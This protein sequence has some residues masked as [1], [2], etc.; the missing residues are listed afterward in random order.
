MGDP[1]GA[2]MGGPVGGMGGPGGETGDPAGAMG[3]PARAMGGPLGGAILL[4][5]RVT[6]PEQ[7]ASLLEEG[8]VLLEKWMILLEQRVSLLEQRVILLKQQVML[9]HQRV[10]LLQVM[11]E[12]TLT[13]KEVPRLTNRRQHMRL[14][15]SSSSKS[16]REALAKADGQND[17]VPADSDSMIELLRR[18]AC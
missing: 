11:Q 6:L 9:Q 1:A 4:D 2:I 14:T 18:F 3:D 7:W 12:H 13:E 10:I 17:R 15:N 8:V 5:K 16:S